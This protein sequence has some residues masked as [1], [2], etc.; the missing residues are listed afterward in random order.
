MG[1]KMKMNEEKNDEN[2]KGGN[3]QAERHKAGARDRS[4]M[5]INGDDNN[6]KLKGGMTKRKDKEGGQETRENRK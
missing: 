1:T 4:K 6:K 2:P 5:K 3:G